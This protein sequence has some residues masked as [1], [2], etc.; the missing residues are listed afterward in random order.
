M[1]PDLSLFGGVRHY[2]E[3]DDAAFVFGLGLPLPVF[4]RNQGAIRAAEIELQK[5]EYERKA[6]EAS[7]H[8]FFVEVYQSV[9]ASYETALLFQKEI[10]PNAEKAF[11]A[12]TEAYKEGKVDY[13]T[14]LDAQR[15]YFESRLDFL[16]VLSSY[17]MT[18]A[19]LEALIGR[20][21]REINRSE[22]KK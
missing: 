4:N 12:A 22:K 6:T 18:R 20:D 2:N 11:L 19:R 17:H 5:A 1:V 7:L 13:L 21:I 16:N 9:A 10:L 8:S 15:T 14:V 3:R